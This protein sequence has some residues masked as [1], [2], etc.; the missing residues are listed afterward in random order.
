VVGSR[1]GVIVCLEDVATPTMYITVSRSLYWRWHTLIYTAYL[2][3]VLLL[4]LAF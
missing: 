3:A 1:V 2:L 4:L